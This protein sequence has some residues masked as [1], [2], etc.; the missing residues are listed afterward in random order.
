M[1]HLQQKK[2]WADDA[3]KDQTTFGSE[4]AS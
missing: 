3:L 2:I 1:Y 4:S